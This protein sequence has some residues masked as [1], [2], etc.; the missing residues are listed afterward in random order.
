MSVQGLPAQ[1]KCIGLKEPN[2]FHQPPTW[3]FEEL[4]CPQD[5]KP[6]R[7]TWTPSTKRRRRSGIAWSKKWGI[8]I[9]SRSLCIYLHSSGGGPRWP[10]DTATDDYSG[11]SGI[12]PPPNPGFPASHRTQ[13]KFNSR[14]V[15]PASFPP[16]P[17][18]VLR[19]SLGRTADHLPLVQYAPRLIAV[20]RRAHR[21]NRPV[22]L[23]LKNG[24]LRSHR[25]NCRNTAR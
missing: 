12:H 17:I 18:V 19:R 24:N 7:R 21:S 15:A 13:E 5:L 6:L 8:D 16:N 10:N 2:A 11:L 3:R 4:D 1:A 20:A 23:A 14:L 9:R 22:L 25:Q